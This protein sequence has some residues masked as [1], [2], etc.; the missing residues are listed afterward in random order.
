MPAERPKKKAEKDQ[1]S[2]STVKPPTVK[3][4]GMLSFD[5]AAAALGLSKKALRERLEA[6][7]LSHARV[8]GDTY[9]TIPAP[10]P[11]VTGGALGGAVPSAPTRTEL[12]GGIV[13]ALMELTSAAERV[14]AMTEGIAGTLSALA[15]PP[16]A[17][18]AAPAP[19][20]AGTF[21]EQVDAQV[22]RAIARIEADGD[23]GVFSQFLNPD[24]APLPDCIY[25]H[26]R[27][28]GD[29]EIR[30]YDIQLAIPS[31][32]V[33]TLEAIRAKFGSRAEAQRAAEDAVGAEYGAEYGARSP[34]A[35]DSMPLTPLTPSAPFSEMQ[36]RVIA[37]HMSS[38]HG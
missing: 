1:A 9:V 27:L 36:E 21:G 17:A 23:W 16:V 13:T 33:A 22:E 5:E 4:V 32:A 2:S 8:G 25:R 11:P 19:Q 26:L 28:T 31:R 14:A 30:E 12:L 35:F 7:E 20:P 10:A 34:R 29:A 15:A 18:A 6:G 37:G 3:V 24:F 38:V